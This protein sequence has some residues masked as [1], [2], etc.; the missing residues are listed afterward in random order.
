[1]STAD[2]STTSTS[3]TTNPTTT[4]AT[5]TPESLNDKIAGDVAT[6]ASVAA[7]FTAFAG[8]YAPIA[9]TVV[10][11]IG[12]LAGAEPAMYDQIK[13][14]LSAAPTAADF[15]ALLAEENALTLD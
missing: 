10:S 12:Y 11:L 6:A 3:T 5:T 13:R 15:T 14:A 8:P 9:A 4:P 7:P 2:A 1:M